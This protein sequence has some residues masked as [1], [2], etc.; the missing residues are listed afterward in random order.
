MADKVKQS[1]SCC[2]QRALAT[3]QNLEFMLHWR[4]LIRIYALV[5]QINQNIHLSAHYRQNGEWNI[6][7]GVKI[8]EEFFFLQAGTFF[9]FIRFCL[10]REVLPS[11]RRCWSLSIYIKQFHKQTFPS[12]SNSNWLVFSRKLGVDHPENRPT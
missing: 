11:I 5:L 6:I 4:N 12:C 7:F 2:L 10:D 3:W 8:K 1:C 9:L